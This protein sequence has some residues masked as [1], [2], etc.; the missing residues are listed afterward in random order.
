MSGS[1]IIRYLL[2][3]NS[4]LIAVVPADRIKVGYIRQGMTLPAIS[5]KKITGDQNNTLSMNNSPYLIQHRVQVTLAV[6]HGET[7]ADIWALVRA[8]LPVSRGTVNGFT[9]ETISLDSEGPDLEDR[10]TQADTSSV[11]YLVWFF[12]T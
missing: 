7:V 2:K 1:S 8:A 6:K 12:R 4:N 9:C 5:V 10:Q 3:T 11:D